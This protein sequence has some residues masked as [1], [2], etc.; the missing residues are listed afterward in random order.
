MYYQANI[1]MATRCGELLSASRYRSGLSRK[2]MSEYMGVSESTIKAWE[3]GQGSPTL[4]GML[5]WYRVTGASYFRAMLDFFWPKPF[6]G[7]KGSDSGEKI[8]NA[9]MTYLAQV[10]GP[11]EIKKL[12]YLI[13]GNHGSEWSGL[14][15]MACALEHTSMKS[16][17][18]IAEIIQAS[19][20]I[21]RANDLVT[22]VPGIDA[23]IDRPLL[24]KAIRAAEAAQ[25][26]KQNGYT[27]GDVFGKDDAIVSQILL[28]AREDAG[29]SRKDLAKALGKT[30]RTIQNWESGFNPSFL[31]IC[32]WFHAIEKSA[33]AY[34]QC[35]IYSHDV[36]RSDAEA[37]IRRQELLRYFST[38]ENCEIRKVSF[39]IM[40]EHGSN[41]LAVLEALF[42]HV[43]S[44]LSQRVI[45]ARSILVSYLVDV[46]HTETIATG[47]I[48]PDID[49]LRRCIELGTEAAKSGKPTFKTAQGT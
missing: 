23:D 7:L 1:E 26:N 2:A 33:W 45:S 3:D 49:N 47:N 14:L 17:Y 20:D 36:H 31:D 42:E 22:K 41:W 46:Q 34:I 9:L 40:G 28:Q 38:A 44:P 27:L 18:R 39:L 35:S 16:R 21:S 4:F 29:V 5:E 10:A 43:C 13:L 6:R 32:M 11:I 12:H 19:Y 15:D 37:E 25:R 8:K 48:L 24:S 30:E